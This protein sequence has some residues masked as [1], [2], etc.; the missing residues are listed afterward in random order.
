MRDHRI[1]PG[2]KQAAPDACRSVRRCR[3]PR[4]LLWA[5]FAALVARL[6]VVAF[7][8]QGF[9]A[10]GRQHWEF[11]YE[12]GQLARSIVNG[13]GLS[14]PY[15]AP[16]GPTAAITPVLPYILAGFFKIFGVFSKGAA[17]AMLGLNSL[18]SALICFPVFFIARKSWGNRTARWSAWMWAFF[19]YGIYFS[20][21]SMWDH[22]LVALLVALLMLCALH[23]ENSTNPWQW[24]GFGALWGLSAL[25]NPVVLGIL[26]FLGGW[27]CYRLARRGKIWLL[28]AATAALLTAA[29]IAPWLVRN[30]QTF[31]RPVF[32]KDNFW[33]EVCVG[34]V[35]NALHWWNGA[36]H[37]VGSA[38]ETA[39]MV[40]VGEPAYMAEKRQEAM[41]YIQGRP[42]VFLRRS[43]RRVVYIWT[44][45]WSFQREYLREE[46]LDPENIF[47]CSMFT[48]LAFVGL[49]QSF[50]LGKEGAVP[51]ALVL[52]TFPAAYYLTHP[53]MGYRHPMDPLIVILAAFAIVSWRAPLPEDRS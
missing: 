47:F 39:E 26:P 6:A 48:I 53:E 46:P 9:L 1:M 29:I 24:A 8:Y 14:D 23:L 11:G 31:H 37:P 34:N 21:S 44:G 50:R 49:I 13:R 40:R 15:M 45:Y 25:T 19:P 51:F 52:L 38:Q 33:L 16:T 7:L 22:T 32:L 36:E 42:G 12:I 10:P 2:E 5:F 27:V 17:L 43:L 41:D 18:F 4:T 28:P 3:V 30:Y 20:A 35:G